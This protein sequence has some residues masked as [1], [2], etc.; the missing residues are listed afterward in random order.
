MGN[1]HH[2]SES[3]SN[4][5]T[6]KITIAKHLTEDDNYDQKFDNNNI[7]NDL[8]SADMSGLGLEDKNDKFNIGSAGNENICMATSAVS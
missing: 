1:K 3:L 5:Q 7:R 4:L 6:K 2:K 8:Y